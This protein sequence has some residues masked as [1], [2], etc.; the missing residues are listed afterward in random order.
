M[1][2]RPLPSPVLTTWREVVN[3][4]VPIQGEI[5][6]YYN[7]LG[8]PTL[9]GGGLI[10]DVRALTLASCKDDIANSV[11]FLNVILHFGEH[12]EQEQP[13]RLLV[14][15]PDTRLSM[16]KI[17]E[18]MSEYI[19]R[20]LV[21]MIQFRL[22]NMIKNILASMQKGAVGT[23]YTSNIDILLPKLHLPNLERKNQ[24]LRILQYM[25]NTYHNNGTH[26]L[27]RPINVHLDKYAYI[28]DKNQPID[29]AS[30]GHVTVAIRATFEVV[31]E[32]LSS[33]PV[34]GL[35]WPVP[36]HVYL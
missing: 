28:F 26:L 30:W 13:F 29:C 5:I 17:L 16:Q 2:M 22:D 35:A 18:R 20:S 15:A 1:I 10:E 14:G 34:K 25:R 7:K 4:L 31:D 27:G 36:V 9:V 23:S 11:A 19:K 21:T 33:A 6:G 24:I 3:G 8:Y 12:P 32:I